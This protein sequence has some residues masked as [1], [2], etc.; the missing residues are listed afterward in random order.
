MALAS[1]L[2][3]GDPRLEACLVDHAAHV[4][5]GDQ[6]DHV[7]K[8]QYAVMVL[9][10]GTINNREME[11]MRY[12]PDTARLVKAYK[13]QRRI[14]NFS[15]QQTADDIVGKMTIAALDKEMV[16][17]EVLEYSRSLIPDPT[18]RIR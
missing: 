16:V 3:A 2:F 8:I 6:G 18:L 15:Y 7:G 10:G 11:Q 12:G 9:D 17:F 4:V 1:R 5:E 14:I 13:T